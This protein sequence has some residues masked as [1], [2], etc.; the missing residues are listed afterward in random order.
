MYTFVQ[1]YV[2]NA[3]LNSTTQII[4]QLLTNITIQL[5]TTCL[6][7]LQYS[8]LLSLS[9][10]STRNISHQYVNKYVPWADSLF[11]SGTSWTAWEKLQSEPRISGTQVV[12]CECSHPQCWISRQSSYSSP[13]C[14]LQLLLPSPSQTRN[15]F[16]KAAGLSIYIYIYTSIIIEGQFQISTVFQ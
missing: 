12:A 15:G 2:C 7:I 10:R 5:L 6:L 16:S 9:I 11:S 3:T 1:A 8:C 13:C 14:I 4:L